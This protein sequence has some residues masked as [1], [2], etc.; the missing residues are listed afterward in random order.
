MNIG[1]IPESGSTNGRE[2]ISYLGTSISSSGGNTIT[3]DHEFWAFASGSDSEG[4]YIDLKG[5]PA[6][7][8]ASLA[9]GSGNFG[10]YFGDILAMA[11]SYNYWVKDQ[12]LSEYTASAATPV[13]KFK[14]PGLPT[15]SSTQSPIPVASSSLANY[16]TF[17]F[18]SSEAGANVLGYEDFGLPFLIER[19]DEIRVTYDINFTGS[20]YS[21]ITPDVQALANY[22][23]QDFVVKDI[24]FSTSTS[25]T[26]LPSIVFAN[27]GPS[28]SISSSRRFDRI[29]VNPNPAELAEPIPSGSI[30][31]FTIRRKIN[32]DDRIIIYQ[33]PPI[34]ALGSQT[35][36]GD[37]YLIPNDF[38]PTQKKNVQT[39]INQLKN[40]N[41]VNT[42]TTAQQS[43]NQGPSS[44]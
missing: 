44:A 7:M 1:I 34:N 16:N 23:T 5:G 4:G 3:Y 38:T 35:P 29:Y 37:G 33:T 22:R 19:G 25:S 40:Q 13:A 24:G 27:S 30:Y 21:D 14:V 17:N 28:A 41:A 20:S 6:R 31:Q 10:F 43:P 26:G 36:T 42:S 15:A 9:P 32:A 2:V 8:S 18:S 12:L 11:H 39:L